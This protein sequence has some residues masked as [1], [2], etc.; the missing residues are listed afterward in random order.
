MND[1]SEY[2]NSLPFCPN[3]QVNSTI[4]AQNEPAPIELC[5]PSKLE[6][7]N[8]SPQIPTRDNF[9]EYLR[10][11]YSD[12]EIEKFI[13]AS[14]VKPTPTEKKNH[15]NKYEKKTNIRNVLLLSKKNMDKPVCVSCINPNTKIPDTVP[16]ASTT[17][18]G[19]QENKYDKYHK[20]NHIK[21]SR[22]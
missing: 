22:K 19:I 21:I 4:T 8:P 5:T 10:K 2:I 18:L 3:G 17:N 13:S 15:Y 7:V 16:T 9:I 6:A 20:K 11:K 14:Q 1:L 12:E